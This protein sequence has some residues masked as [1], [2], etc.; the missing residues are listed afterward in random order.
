MTLKHVN[1]KEITKKNLKKKSNNNMCFES[2]IFITTKQNLSCKNN[3][4]SKTFGYTHSIGH[5]H[6]LQELCKNVDNI[7]LSST[8]N[9]SCINNSMYKGNIIYTRYIIS[10]NEYMMVCE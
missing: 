9:C 7:P 10:S 2:T 5:A 6:L 3:E 4:F 1:K 8:W